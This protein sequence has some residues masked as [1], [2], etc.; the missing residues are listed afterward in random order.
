VLATPVVLP[1]G[2]LLGYV[3]VFRDIT[4]IMQAEQIKDELILQLSHELRTPLTAAR[5][6]VDLLQMMEHNQLSERGISFVGNAMDSLSTLER[7]VNQ[8]IDVSAIMADRFTIETTHV[9]LGEVLTDLVEKWTPL[10]K[11]RDHQI[12]VNLL[13]R[14]I[15]VEADA[16]RISQVFDHLI[17]NAYSYTLPGGRIEVVADVEQEQAAVYIIDN[18]V[19]IAGDEIEM[20]FE[21]LYRGRSADA[22]PTDARGLGLGLY[23]AERIVKAHG[24]TLSLQSEVDFGT[25]VSVKLPL[26]QVR[27]TYELAEGTAT[28]AAAAMGD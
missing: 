19:G 27:T 10:V 24:G 14:R 3:L 15:W 26:L 16:K 9:N 4:A 2:E 7:M 22:G 25:V 6:Y 12:V 11:Q 23:F 8:V 1:S 20:V 21:R 28:H 17:R 5:G 18:G 13:Y